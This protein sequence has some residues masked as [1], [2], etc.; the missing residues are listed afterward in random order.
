MCSEFSIATAGSTI[1]SGGGRLLVDAHEQIG[2]IDRVVPDEPAAIEATR[3][4]LSYLLYD[5]PSGEP[6]PTAANI[7]AIVALSTQS[8]MQTASSSF[9]QTGGP[10]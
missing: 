6:S 4:Y 5:V 7:A 8:R 3:K 2:D 10:R 1:G 9:V